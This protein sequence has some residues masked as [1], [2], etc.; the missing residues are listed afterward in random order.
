M[1]QLQTDLEIFLQ[2]KVLITENTSER[3]QEFKDI[4]NSFFH[5]NKNAYNIT[6]FYVTCD[7][8]NNYKKED[9][10]VAGIQYKTINSLNV[11]YLNIYI[12][13]NKRL[14]LNKKLKKVK[15]VEV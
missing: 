1:T 11:N 2:N 12:N 3:R 4:L 14:V 9:Y 10:L 5:V 8:T 7:E 15:N 13:G 6:D